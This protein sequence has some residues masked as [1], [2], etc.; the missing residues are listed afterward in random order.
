MLMKLAVATL[1]IVFSVWAEAAPTYSTTLK[2]ARSNQITSAIGNAGLLV[3][4]TSALNGATGV[5]CTVTLGSPVAP[6]ASSGV[7]TFTMP[8]TCTAGA[9]GAAAKA[10]LRT[11]G[12]T[13]VISGLSVT[14]TG[15]GGDVQLD[16]TSVANNQVLTVNS[17]VITE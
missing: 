9:S 1:C 7:L 10:S 15:G 11:S 2:N 12:G 5:L 17:L 6:S 8:Q 3:I 14:V 16:N 13:D 4:G